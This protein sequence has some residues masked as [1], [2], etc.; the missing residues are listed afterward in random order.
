MVKLFMLITTLAGG[1]AEKVASELSINLSSNVQRRIVTLIDKINYPSNHPPISIG[2]TNRNPHILNMIYMIVVGTI[3]YRQLLKKHKP[4][5]SMSFLVL[6]AIINIFSN[7]GNK[8]TRV[9][10]SVHTNLSMKFQ[11]AYLRKVAKFLI[12]LIYEHADIIIAVSEGVKDDLINNFHINP[13]KIKVIYNPFDLVKIKKLSEEK[14]N[15]TYFSKDIP[16]LINVGGLKEAK[17]QW[18]LIRAFS[19]VRT[20]IE[21]KLLICGEGELKSYLEKLVKDLKLENSVEFLGWQD[22]PYKYISKSDIF[23]FTSLWEALPCVMIEAMACG[24]PIIATDCKY[25]PREILDNGNCGIIVPP[26]K[27]EYLNAKDS[28]SSDEKKLANTIVNLLQNYELHSL[29]VEKSN[30]RVKH[31]DMDEIINEYELVFENLSNQSNL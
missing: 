1:G 4:D 25:G 7:V 17:A 22:N 6:D 27:R 29:Y 9:V 13:T 31:F 20:Q 2:F 12:Q 5:I 18:N 26:M 30:V 19:L 23:V 8:N 14:V 28:I 15:E 24:C 10:I 11:N 16:T 21:C 3:K